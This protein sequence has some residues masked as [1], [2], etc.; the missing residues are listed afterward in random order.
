MTGMIREMSFIGLAASS[1]SA[2]IKLIDMPY[3]R[4]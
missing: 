2:L 1:P 4:S 3:R